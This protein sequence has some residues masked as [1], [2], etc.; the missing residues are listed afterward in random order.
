MVI[1]HVA[2]TGKT[3][4]NWQMFPVLASMGGL[5]PSSV[6]VAWRPVALILKRI[7]GAVLSYRL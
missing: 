7:V 6:P 3:C 2:H 1:G 5:D 4:D